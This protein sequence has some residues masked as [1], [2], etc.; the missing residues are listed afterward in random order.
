MSDSPNYFQLHGE[1]LID[2]GY[3]IIPIMPGSKKPGV[4]SSSGGW[5]NMQSWERYLDQP[6]NA[7][8][9]NLWKRWPGAGI[10][11]MCGDTIGFDIDTLDEELSFRLRSCI[12]GVLGE[13]PAV[14]VGRAPKMMLNYRAVGGR[15]RKRR[16]GPLEVLG[17]GQQFVAYA[18][19]PDTQ[20]PYAWPIEHL[21]D[22]PLEDLPTCTPEQL[23]E[24]LRRV[25]EILPPDM[26]RTLEQGPAA[27][28]PMANPVLEGTPEAVALAL[29][30][31]PNPDLHWEE[32]NRVGMAIFAATGGQGFD[33]FDGWSSTS[34]KYDA[35]ACR[36]RW[37]SYRRSPPRRI[38]AG[39]I[40]HL[41]MEHGWVAPFDVALNAEK[42][43]IAENPIDVSKLRV[44]AAVAPPARQAPPPPPPPPAP[45]AKNA[46]DLPPGSRETFPHAWFDTRSL[47]GDITRWIVNTAQ[48]PLPTFALA[49]T[50]VALGTMFGRRYRTE[51]T[52]TRTNLYAVAIAKPGMG[53]D[54]SRQCIKS[55]F[56]ASGLDKL[57]C[58]DSFSSGSAM[59][60][61][62][63]DYPSRISHMDELGMMLEQV[64][65]K[66]ASPHQRGIVK[67]LLELFSSSSGIYNGQEYVDNKANE[68][69]DLV[70]PNFNVFG[71]TT[72]SSLA[73][74]LKPA[75]AENGMLSRILLVPP[76]ED[77]PEFRFVERT[78]TPPAALVDAMKAFWEVKKPGGNLSGEQHLSASAV[79]LISVAWEPDAL[80]EL[81]AIKLTERE[82]G[83]Q[84]RYIWVR[85]TELA[86]KIAMIEAIA[87]DPVRPIITSEI[88]AMSRDL[89]AWLLSYAESFFDDQVSDNETEATHKKVLQIVKRAGLITGSDLARA[90]QFLKKREREEVMQTLVDAGQ[91]AVRL[92][93]VGQR[94]APTKIYEA[95]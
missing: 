31:I 3:S 65:M 47:V 6:A 2:N 78:R 30:A 74:A 4:W 46:K 62:L 58:G 9:V 32:W 23:E 33:V 67:M 72:P 53:K 69:V 17:E 43:E 86:T 34:S 63:K 24:V 91:I 10:G 94:G 14:R 66:T 77:Y 19:H 71:S 89:V 76:F 85:S 18:T 49:N 50:L 61:A 38:G 11:I 51:F 44:K 35:A 68:R 55:L 95:A 82:R 1:R 64:A 41:A 73:P 75:M 59:L 13:T 79:S 60:R 15:M 42:A 20:K 54:H 25:R 90:T 22:I 8:Q 39:T 37:A 87:R 27:G 83:R 70:N 45:P 92:Q 52:D 57:L 12:V 81:K 84:G 80:E 93:R 29:E 56:M 26:T 28:A 36:E 5:R 7:Y 16:V 40:Y 21:A 88:I 48:D